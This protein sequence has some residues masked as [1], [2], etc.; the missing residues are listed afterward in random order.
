[1]V[2]GAEA[3]L[4]GGGADSSNSEGS[5]SGVSARWESAE[6][7]GS[8]VT[9]WLTSLIVRAGRDEDARSGLADMMMLRRGGREKAE[10]PWWD[11]SPSRR[12]V[13]LSSELPQKF[14]VA[15]RQALNAKQVSSR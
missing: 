3:P 12:G 4:G 7:T 8:L 6:G 9:E 15:L 2:S 11:K 5:M 14:G 10:G 13:A 1:M